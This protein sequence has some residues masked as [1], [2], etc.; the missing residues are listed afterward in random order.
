IRVLFRSNSVDISPDG[1]SVYCGRYTNSA[2]NIAHNGWQNSPGGFS[3]A[4]LASFASSDG[5]LNWSTYYGGENNEECTDLVVA[6]DGTIFFTGT[7]QSE[8]NIASVGAHQ[9]NLSGYSDAFLVA[10]DSNGNRLWASYYGGDEDEDFPELTMQD[11]NLILFGSTGSSNNI[12]SGNPLDEG[13]SG[14][15]SYIAK[16]DD[17]GQIL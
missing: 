16:F 9:E 5:T 15:S 7:T 11:Q 10:L 12:A 8:S 2:N 1:L 4:T 17:T 3:D 6:N 13:G 14:Y